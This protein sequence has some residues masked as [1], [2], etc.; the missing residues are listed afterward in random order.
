M[1]P[2]F[3][4]SDGIFRGHGLGGMVSGAEHRDTVPGTP[5]AP[6]TTDTLKKT[7]DED[8]IRFAEAGENPD[9]IKGECPGKGDTQLLFYI[10]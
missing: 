7:G 4:D 3:G 2:G 6:E 10:T 1:R 9:R 8:G 5:A